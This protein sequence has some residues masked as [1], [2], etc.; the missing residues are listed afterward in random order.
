MGRRTPLYDRHVE[1]GATMVDFAGYEMPQQYS[2]IRA[3]HVA[4]RERAG[5]FDVSHM[6]EVMVTGPNAFT[7]VQRLVTNDVTR[8]VDGKALYGVMC[9]EKGGI[10]DDVIVYRDGPDRYMVVVNAACR[11]KDVA[12]I[13]RH[14]SGDVRVEDI[15]DDISLLAVQGPKAVE[16]VAEICDADLS[17][18]NPFHCLHATV[19]GVPARVS[20]TGYTGEDG[21]ELYADAGDAVAVWDAVI[22]AGKSVDL[23]PCG[24]GARDTLRLESG[25]RLYGQDMDDQ[26]DPF[27]C[28]LAWTVKMSKGGF[29]GRDAL[30]KLDPQDPPRRF[31]GLATSAKAIPRHGAKTFADGREVGVVTSGGFSFTLGHGIATATVDSSVQPGVPLTIEV[32]GAQVDSQRVALP[33]YRRPAQVGG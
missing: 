24:L 17:A 30:V 32:R 16:V 1:A 9:S 14:V 3:E 31:L 6:G 4:V 12:W 21:V 13:V 19:A 11:E 33:F 7:N 20:R 22:A 28:G 10:V 5:I 2:S 8:L 15:S 26:T 27:S 18:L 29:V 25:L 23:L